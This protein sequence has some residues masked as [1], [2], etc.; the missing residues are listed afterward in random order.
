MNLKVPAILDPG[1]QP[2]ALV[3]HQFTEAAKAAGG[4]KLIIGIERNKGY[5]ST[6]EMT[7]FADGTVLARSRGSATITCKL[8]NGVKTTC[9]VIVQ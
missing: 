4:E 3:F 8:S 5:V 7:V 1:F 9:E 2:M 6:F